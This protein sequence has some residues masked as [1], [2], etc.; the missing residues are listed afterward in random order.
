MAASPA[1]Q[2]RHFPASPSVEK[3]TSKALLG[4]FCTTICNYKILGKINVLQTEEEGSVK[5]NVYLGIEIQILKND[6]GLIMCQRGEA[7][8]MLC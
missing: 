2:D 4:V 6:K 3:H 7:S 5:C 1:I 8:E